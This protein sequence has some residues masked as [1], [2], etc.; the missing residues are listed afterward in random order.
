VSEEPPR[1]PGVAVLVSFFLVAALAVA[2]AI[3][4]GVMRPGGTGSSPTPTKPPKGE[5]AVAYPHAPLSLNPYTFEGDTIAT[6]DLDRPVLPTLLQVGPDLR[7]HPSLAVRVPAGRDVVATPFSVTYHLDSRAIWSDGQPLTAGDVRFTWQSILD[8]RFAIADRSAY[9]HVTDAVVVD[10]HTV[11]LQF[12]GYYVWWPDLFSAGD[13]V[14]PEHDL[15][16]RDLGSELRDGI[17]VGAGPFVVESWTPGLE[18]VYAANPRWWGRGPRF[19]RVRVFFVPDAEMAIQLLEQG[20]VQALALTTEPNLASRLR[21][22]P[23]THVSARYGSA[24]WELVFQHEGPAVRNPVYRQAIAAAVDRKGMVEAF[25]RD[26]GR[27]LES[28][29]PGWGPGPSEAFATV[30]LDRERSKQI[31]AEA[32]IRS[33]TVALTAPSNS[34]LAAMLQRAIQAGLDQVGIAAEIGNPDEDR[35]YGKWLRDGRW[36]LA[37]VERRGSP[38]MALAGTYR[39]NRHPPAGVNY[40]RLSSAA[41]DEVLDAADGV[42]NTDPALPDVV[43][44]RLAEALPA[45]PLLEAKAFIAYKPAIGGP[46][47]NATVEG[48]FWN[49]Q[50]W[51][52]DG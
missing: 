48:P 51:R 36:D 12:D 39:S 7:Y 38:M 33:G 27:G 3:G 11:R 23:R 17:R 49:L 18:I 40:A 50:D 43:M 14:L 2:A 5:I 22:D 13:F 28:L 30:G 15:K 32:G 24:W 45:L 1:R 19:Q 10:P 41:V 8:R 46:S 9:Q 34:E 25:V 42:K 35:F 6:R 26:D 29:A 31:L 37:L 44:R 20:K 47:A 16:G 21:D 4:F 52:A